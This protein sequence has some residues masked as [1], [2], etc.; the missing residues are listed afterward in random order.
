MRIRQIAEET[1]RF[2]EA[3]R[4]E[5]G[6]TNYAL[7][8]FT[9][10]GENPEIARAVAAITAGGVRITQSEVEAIMAS[11]GFGRGETVARNNAA[12]NA[13]RRQALRLVDV[14]ADAARATGE[15]GRDIAA[16]LDQLDAVAEGRMALREVAAAMIERTAVAEQQLAAATAEAMQLRVDLEEA[17]SEAM[18]DHL[19]GLPNRR[20]SN[21]EVQRLTAEG[22]NWSAAMIDV[23]DFKAINDR[24]GHGVG[25]RVLKAVAGTLAEMCA[26]H[27]VGRWGGEEFVVLFEGMDAAKATVIVDRARE[28]VG[29]RRM[30]LRES[31]EPLG[32]VSFSAGVAGASLYLDGDTIERADALLYAAKQAG[33]D[34]V[35]AAA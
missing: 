27:F 35:L 30:R 4:L 9:V 32:R 18:M 19:T 17:R 34:R 12:A 3:H 33:K 11:H 25:D 7:G 15:F 28:A 10:T 20:G 31:D 8:Y 23:D 1:I 14:T 5:P 22:T 13:V 26:P 2:L 16:N 21:A 24:F 29:D 6:P